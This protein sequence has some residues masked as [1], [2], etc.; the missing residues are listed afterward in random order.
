MHVLSFKPEVIL[1]IYMASC[2]AVL[3][4]NILYIFADK[5]SGKKRERSSLSFVGKITEQT[6]LLREGKETDA[7]HFDEMFR[8]LKKRKIWRL[9][10]IPCWR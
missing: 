2:I 5:Y 10:R 1:Y 8:G 9:L 3:I 4:F 6:E 7:A